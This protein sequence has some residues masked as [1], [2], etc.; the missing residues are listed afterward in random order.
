MSLPVVLNL[1]LAAIIIFCMLAAA[2]TLLYEKAYRATLW[3]FIFMLIL[4]LPF[5]IVMLPVV[6]ES[7]YPTF[8]L[9]TLPVILGII[10]Y[11]PRSKAYAGQT[12]V[13]KFD[14]RETMFS[15]RELKPGTKNFQKYYIQHPEHL[16]LDNTWRQKPGLMDEKAAFYDPVTFAAAEASFQTIGKMGDF[17]NGAVKEDKKQISQEK[18][19]QFIKK[20]M[21]KQGMA[22]VGITKM[23]DYHYYHTKGRGSTY[24][25]QVTP[26]YPY[27]IAITVEMDES[28]MDAAPKGS[29]VMESAEKYLKSGVPA[30]QLAAFLREMGYEAQAHIDGNYEVVCPLVAKDA[31]LGEVG[32]MGLLMSPKEGPRVRIAVVTTNA[33]LVADKPS[34]ISYSMNEFCTYCKKCAAVCPSQ[35]IPFDQRKMHDGTLRWKINSETCFTYWQTVGTDCGRCMAV[36]PYAHANNWLHNSI[37]FGIRHSKLFRRLAVV[38]DDLFY[39]KRPQSR[40][41]PDWIP[42]I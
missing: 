40:N 18:L 27:G 15:R 36:C 6:Q 19:A 23:Q 21:K 41:M 38:L 37:R 2:I 9:S 39:G 24:N 1:I 30:V 34:D 31:G 11:N 35:S 3:S 17:I 10:L 42:K 32:R 8:I 4:P 16:D 13:K 14:E 20:W 5:A 33:P 29:A 25:K 28:M 22:D 7:I 26:Q 12:P